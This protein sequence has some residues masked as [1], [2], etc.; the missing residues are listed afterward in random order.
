MHDSFSLTTPTLMPLA[1]ISI[2]SFSFFLPWHKR[3]DSIDYLRILIRPTVALHRPLHY[4]SYT[5]TQHNITLNQKLPFSY[6]HFHL[7]T[8]SNMQFISTLPMIRRNGNSTINIR[9][10][11]YISLCSL[12]GATAIA[13]VLLQTFLLLSK[14]NCAFLLLVQYEVQSSIIYSSLS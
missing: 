6:S 7:S 9:L 1:L 4:C 3:Q 11:A 12:Y 2:S 5:N 8:S 13:V 14:Q 10:W